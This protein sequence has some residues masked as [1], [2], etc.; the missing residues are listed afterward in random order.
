V[1]APG[2]QPSPGAGRSGHERAASGEVNTLV[3]LYSKH[4][5]RIYRY[6]LALLRNPDDA[7][8]ATQ[9]TFTRAAPFLPNLAGDLS[10]YLTTVARNICCDV[11]RARA[12]RPV[13]L[14]NV[15][16][17]DRAV[18][19]ERQSVDWDVVRRMW[20]QLSPSERLLFA[21]TFAGYRYE[22][23]ASRTGMSRPSVSVGLTRARRRLRDLATAIGALGAL[24]LGLRRLLD[25]LTRRANSALA[26]GQQALLE[27]AQQAGAVVAGLLAGL[28]SLGAAG[29]AA[30]AAPAMVATAYHAGAG[31]PPSAGD[32]HALARESAPPSQRSTAPQKPAPPSATPPPAQALAPVVGQATVVLPGGTATPDD[33][34][35]DTATV[36]PTFSQDGI[37]FMTGGVQNGCAQ[38]TCAALFRSDDAGASWTRLWPETYQGG[39]VLLS[40][41]FPAD[42]TVFLI[43][44]GAGLLAGAPGSAGPTLIVPGAGA[45]A[46]APDSAVGRARF[47]VATTNGLLETYTMGDASPLPGPALPAGVIPNS[48]VFTGPDQVLVAGYQPIAGPSGGAQEAVLVSCSLTSTCG[49]PVVFAGETLVSL[50]SAGVYGGPVVGYSSRTVYLSRDGGT[51][52]TPVATAAAGRFVEQAAAGRTPA[53]NRLLTTTSDVATQE[54]TGIA[55]SDDLGATWTDA[56]GNL[57]SKGPTL[58]TGVLDNGDLFVALLA[59]AADHFGLRVSPGNGS[60]AAPRPA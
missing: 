2:V 24:P 49:T 25:R 34:T 18:S 54:R 46:I 19:P 37:V 22:E 31:A 21:Y 28:V 27:V 30:A 32:A 5:R 50:R 7:E 40:P 26:A 11:V 44:G 35:A 23:I 57:I 33:T 45:V 60:W 42:P 55:Y 15:A 59:D 41:R 39:A 53:G 4:E 29:T 6:C 14:D 16:V 51:G 8:D 56:T 9:E 10:A 58:E 17:P 52:F 20:R 3:D 1:T 43:L 38:G 36:S 13:P 12:R 48:L 47:A